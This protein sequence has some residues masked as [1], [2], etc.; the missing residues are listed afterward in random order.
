MKFAVLTSVLLLPTC[1]AA[2]PR[3]V[4]LSTFALQCETT[5][6]VICVD[7]ADLSQAQCQAVI[8]G[9][10]KQINAAVGRELLRFDGFITRAGA[11]NAVRIGAIVVEGHADLGK[12]LGRD[13]LQVF[14]FTPSSMEARDGTV[15]LTNT[16]LLLDPRLFTEWHEFL[17]GVVMHEMLHA[18]GIAHSAN[19]SSPTFKSIMAPS[20][21][22]PSHS[23]TL[24]PADIYSLHAIYG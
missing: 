7:D 17:G 14:G 16:L 12:A 9:V 23:E 6:S 8:P 19:F 24:T 1:S 18:I 21:T 11:S 15:C 5:R 22:S 4:T 10:I 13:E 3:A 20:A 2:A